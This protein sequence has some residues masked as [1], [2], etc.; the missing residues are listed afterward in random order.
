MKVIIYNLRLCRDCTQAAVNNDYTGLDYRYQEPE[1]TE[2][3]E[4]IQA[5]LAELGPHL[6]CSGDTD[7]FSTRKC[8]CCKTRLAGE[9]TL[10]CIIGEE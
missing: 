1:A 8:D 4:E 5:G 6:V 2:R 9:R 7:E 3:M 10:F